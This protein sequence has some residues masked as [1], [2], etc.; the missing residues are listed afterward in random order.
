MMKFPRRLCVEEKRY[1]YLLAVYTALVST[2]G[3]ELLTADREAISESLVA[4]SV[5]GDQGVNLLLGELYFDKPNV[6]DSVHVCDPT[7][8]EEKQQ[9]SLPRSRARQPQHRRSQRREYQP[10]R[11]D[12]SPSGCKKEACQHMYRIDT[13]GCFDFEGNNEGHIRG[14]GGTVM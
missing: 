7:P 1:V 5:G 4:R 3:D 13:V 12:P 10:C 8:H 6:S 11:I 2:D 9:V 14:R